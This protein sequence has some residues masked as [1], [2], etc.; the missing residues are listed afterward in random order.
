M[1]TMI[2]ANKR[3]ATSWL[4]HISDHD[5]DAMLASTAPDWRMHGGPPQ[6][7]SGHEGVRRLFAHLGEVEQEWTID[8]VIAEDNKVVVRATDVCVQ[9]STFGFP[10]S[11]ISQVFTATFIFRIHD[12]KVAE[13]WRNA[14]DLGRLFQIGVT[15]GPQTAQPSGADTAGPTEDRDCG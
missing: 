7:P 4:Q 2:D 6:L 10:A 9:S 11:G 15:F 8:D 3:L 12:G 5:M 14:D 13:I 1:S